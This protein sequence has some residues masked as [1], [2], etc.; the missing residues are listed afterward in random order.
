MSDKMTDIEL[1]REQVEAISDAVKKLRSSGISEKALVLLI[2][3]A[4]P[5]CG[6]RHDKTKPKATV[7]RAVMQGMENLEAYVFDS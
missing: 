3:H 4:S 2:Q 1:L 5:T 7:I 6:P